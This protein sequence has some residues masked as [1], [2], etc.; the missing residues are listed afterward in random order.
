MASN[1]ELKKYAPLVVT[2]VS[3][4][5]ESEKL[6]INQAKSSRR[7]TFKADSENFS[8]KNSSIFYRS[9]SLAVSF[10]CLCLSKIMRKIFFFFCISSHSQALMALF[11]SKSPLSF[12]EL[13]RSA[14]LSVSLEWP[15]RFVIFPLVLMLLRSCL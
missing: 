13:F 5:S 9:L 7:T 15:L 6:K 10:N 1:T 4:P 8:I 3:V 11:L 2:S 14:L 12:S